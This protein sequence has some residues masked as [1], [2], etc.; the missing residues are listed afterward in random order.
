MERAIKHLGAASKKLEGELREVATPETQKFIDE[1][2]DLE[3]SSEAKV[4]EKE[5]CGK[6]LD[7]LKKE[8]ELIE[9]KFATWRK[10]KNSRK[11]AT[12]L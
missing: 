1:K 5:K 7:A 3:K 9:S 8:Q 6:N 11:S 10:P 4:Q 12:V 2:Q